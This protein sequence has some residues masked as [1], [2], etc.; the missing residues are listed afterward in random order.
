MAGYYRMHRGWQAHPIF[1]TKA[2]SRRDAW[3]WLIENAAW[4]AMKIRIN[5]STVTLER[6]QVSHSVRHLAKAWGWSKSRVARFLDELRDEKMIENA[7]QQRD[8]S[9]TAT[10]T[11]GGTENGTAQNIIT[12][13]NYGKYQASSSEAGTGDGTDF[14][15]GTN[16]KRSESGTNKKKEENKKEEVGGAGAPPYAFVGKIIKLKSQQFDQWRQS[17]RNIDL[18][19]SLQAADDYYFEHPPPDGKWFFPVSNWLRRDN[20]DTAAKK[21]EATRGDDWW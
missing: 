8:S 12:I 13:C 16:E 15:T 6:G 10:R 21:K 2:F 18:V 5:G 11:R 20:T 3:I 1:G 4:Q 14:G 17:Y 9:G 19:A 7:G